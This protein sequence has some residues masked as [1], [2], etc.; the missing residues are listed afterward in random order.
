MHVTASRRRRGL[1][2]EQRA[3]AGPLTLVVMLSVASEKI[4]PRSIELVEI[5]NETDSQ[6]CAFSDRIGID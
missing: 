6:F 4:K 2:I 1:L 5:S 3:C